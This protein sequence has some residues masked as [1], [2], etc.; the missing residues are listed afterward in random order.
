MTDTPPA[1]WRV[2]AAP[3]NWDLTSDEL[4]I[5]PVMMDNYVTVPDDFFMTIQTPEMIQEGDPVAVVVSFRASASDG[6]TLTRI[7]GLG[8]HWERHLGQIVQAFPPSGWAQYAVG[9]MVEFLRLSHRRAEASESLGKLPRLELEVGDR[10]Y[11]DSG[12]QRRR[13]IT[14]EHL[15]EVAK[16]Y[17]AAQRNGTPPTRAVQAHFAVSHSTAAK[18]V[19]AARK[20]GF[21]PPLETGS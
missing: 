17:E 9:V 11:L 2:L 13:R 10:A 15:Q 14:P 16:I 6:V 12:I 20:A 19:G 4:N 18:W 3:S 5:R 21:L 7:T 1:G 8:N